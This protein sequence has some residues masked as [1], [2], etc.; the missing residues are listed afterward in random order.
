MQ[1]K[2]VILGFE[3]PLTGRVGPCHVYVRVNFTFSPRIFR[4]R[5]FEMGN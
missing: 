1:E 4:T 5:D 3:K 2:V